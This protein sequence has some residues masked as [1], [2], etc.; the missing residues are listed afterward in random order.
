MSNITTA[1]NTLIYVCF[2]GGNMAYDITY[3]NLDDYCLQCLTLL[4]NP[5][6]SPRNNT[7]PQQHCLSITYKFTNCT[8]RYTITVQKH[9]VTS[10]DTGAII[11]LVYTGGS[12]INKTVE[13]YVKPAKFDNQYVVFLIVGITILIG[14][15]F[16]LII[17][18]YV[19]QRKSSTSSGY[20]HIAPPEIPSKYQSL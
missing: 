8:S 19:K 15:C 10:N 17:V 9:H 14:V 4:G 5:C 13:L 18:Y 12:F 7:S 16:A 2:A 11:F 1:E 3:R 20:I 6:K